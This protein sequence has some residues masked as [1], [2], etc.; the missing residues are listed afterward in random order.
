MAALDDAGLAPLLRPPDVDDGDPLCPQPLKSGAVH[1]DDIR[2]KRH[3]A[4][5]QQRAE[6]HNP[7][8]G[9]SPPQVVSLQ[10]NRHA[11]VCNGFRPALSSFPKNSP[12]AHSVRLASR[13]RRGARVARS[14]PDGPALIHFPQSPGA[15]LRS[16][17]FAPSARRAVARSGPDGPVL[18]RIISLRRSARSARSCA[19][20]AWTRDPTRFARL[21]LSHTSS[22]PDLIRASISAECGST[23]W[24]AGYPERGRAFPCHDVSWR[25]S[26]LLTRTHRTEHQRPFPL[27]P[28]GR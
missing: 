24:M 19:P 22:C 27:S 18:N 16:L 28:R 3:G 7:Q 17:G 25:S 5:D 15:S 20:R 23:T 4:N 10:M 12:G 6:H 2:M 9:P 21:D 26:G 8:H 14:G 13:L 11:P 1:V